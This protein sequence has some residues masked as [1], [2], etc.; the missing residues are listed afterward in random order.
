MPQPD[1]RF[2][3][4]IRTTDPLNVSIGSGPVI[5]AAA[6]SGPRGPDRTTDLTNSRKGGEADMQTSPPSPARPFTGNLMC[7]TR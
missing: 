7:F 5:G 6:E 3:P 2:R 4:E 1:R